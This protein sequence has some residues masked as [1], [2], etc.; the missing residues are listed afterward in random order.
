MSRLAATPSHEAR[1]SGPYQARSVA[2]HAN[3][4]THAAPNTPPCAVRLKYK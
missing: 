1:E 2:S 3:S 4:S